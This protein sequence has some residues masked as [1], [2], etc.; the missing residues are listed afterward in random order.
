MASQRA[1]FQR[2]LPPPHRPLLK[3]EL[4]RISAPSSSIH[5]FP[6]AQADRRSVYNR[7]SALLHPSDCPI[8]AKQKA[9]RHAERP[10]HKKQQRR[11]AALS[12]SKERRGQSVRRRSRHQRFKHTVHQ[13]AAKRISDRNRKKLKRIAHGKHASLLRPRSSAS[14]F[15]FIS[16]ITL[17][18]SAAPAHH[19]G[20][21]RPNACSWKS[22]AYCRSRAP[23]F[24]GPGPPR[25]PN[26][27]R[28]V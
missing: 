14:R 16:G 28:A 6:A 25:R 4:E 26:C 21:L 23:G 22:A 3:K 18:P 12:G 20:K 7:F 5:I 15:A 27:P 19:T 24:S 13:H 10:Q 2:R 9:G 11:A 1:V 17:H 8:P